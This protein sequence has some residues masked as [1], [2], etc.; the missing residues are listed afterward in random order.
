[1]LVDLLDRQL[2]LLVGLQIWR[3]LFLVVSLTFAGG[4]GEVVSLERGY[5][6][7]GGGSAVLLR[8]C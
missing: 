4:Q 7:E 8:L 5:W 3:D 6:S 1:V 2:G